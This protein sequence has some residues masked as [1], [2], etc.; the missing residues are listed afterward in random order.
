MSKRLLDIETESKT[1][2]PVASRIYRSLDI[3]AFGCFLL[4]KFQLILLLHS[5]LLCWES[6]PAPTDQS[7]RWYRG[8][9]HK[10]LL[11]KP[12]GVS[13]L[14]RCTFPTQEHSSGSDCRRAWSRH[15]STALDREREQ[16]SS[17]PLHDGH[18]H[19]CRVRV[20]ETKLGIS[21]GNMK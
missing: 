9:R 2:F 20:S 1:L 5:L 14:G 11:V 13:D 18:D 7:T 6:Y 16:S 12:L 8:H 21:P 19:R 17:P 10:G 4:I 15:R 3:V